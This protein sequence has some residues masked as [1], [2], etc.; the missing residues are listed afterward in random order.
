MSAIPPRERFSGCLIGQ[1]LG[2]ALGL[3]VEGHPPETCAEYA[4]DLRRHRARFPLPGRGPFV[5]R[6]YTDDSQLAREWMQSYA[7]RRGFDPADY[8]SRICA[9]FAENRIVGRGLATDRAARR[10]AEGIPWQEAGDRR[11]NAGNGTAMRAAPVG[12]V[13]GHNPAEMIRVSREQSWITHQD[14][15]CL[16]GSV[17]IA[18]AVAL[19]VQPGPVHVRSWAGQL[20]EWVRAVDPMFAEEILCLSQ[21][22]A[23]PAVEAAPL[24]ARAGMPD[25][26]DGWKW[27][28]PYVVP[29]VLWSL[30]AFLRT[31]EDYWEAVC[32]TIEA[33]GDVDTT[34][35]MTGAISGAHLGLQSLPL[36][37]AHG[38]QDQG[39]WGFHEL[40]D[41][42]QRCHELAAAQPLPT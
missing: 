7:D 20:A 19:A 23:L 34:G 27:I 12:L 6:Q 17:A 16:A 28:S 13:F 29:S 38:L 22:I 10:L 5:P 32:T 2:D 9:I 25:Y 4:A 42:A 18:G 11:G 40:V 1:C 3:P 30:Y 41:L 14:A 31:P 36:D 37:L 26:N 35:A 8:A 21:W 33:G 15:R 39:T 24:I